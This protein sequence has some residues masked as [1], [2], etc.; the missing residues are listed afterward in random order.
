M[1]RRVSESENAEGQQSSSEESLELA[2]GR[3]RTGFEDGAG[4]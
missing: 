1:K 2:L 4:R 3:P